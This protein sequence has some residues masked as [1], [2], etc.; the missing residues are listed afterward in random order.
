MWILQDSSLQFAAFIYDLKLVPTHD[1]HAGRILAELMAPGTNFHILIALS[2]DGLR[3]VLQLLR[4]LLIIE[5][6]DKSIP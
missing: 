5:A 4:I 3:T 2:R 1:P 6:H